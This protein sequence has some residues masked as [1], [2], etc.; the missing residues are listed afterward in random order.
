MTSLVLLTVLVIPMLAPFDESGMATDAYANLLDSRY[1]DL[2]LSGADAATVQRSLQPLV[3]D[4]F[5]YFKE[6]VN[7]KPVALTITTADGAYAYSWPSMDWNALPERSKDVYET[8]AGHVLIIFD[9]SQK[10]PLLSPHSP[11][12][13]S[14]VKSPWDRLDYDAWSTWGMD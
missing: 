3:I 7:Y 6:Q 2:T 9:I 10:V 5:K 4:F 14:L 13:P 11:S 1:V 8:E 12:S